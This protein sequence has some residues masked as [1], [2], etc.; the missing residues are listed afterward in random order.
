MNAVPRLTVG[1]PVYN[2]EKYLAESLDALLG[3][4]Y[5][6]YRMI[7]SDNASTDATEEICREYQAKDGRITYFRQ[8]VNIGATPNHN[9]CF[10]QSDTELFKWASYD[11]L[12]GRDLLKRC[13]EA[14]DDDPYLVLA[15]AYQAIIDGAGD[16]VLEVDY[17]LDTANPHAPDRFRSLLFDV[18]GDDFYGVMRSD[19]LRRTPLNGSYHHSDRTIMAELALYGRFAQVPELLFFRRD[20]PDR[21]ERAKPTIRSRSANMEPRRASRLRNPT[22]RL[23]AEYVNGFVGGIRRAPLSVADRREC[24]RHLMSWL[25]SRAVGRSTGRIEDNLPAA[26]PARIPESSAV[27]RGEAS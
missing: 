4:S 14:L 20:H 7:I 18:G 8:P 16:I 9:W 1:L 25:A 5:G 3:Q 24:Y 6:D 19:I 2:G 10:E 11:D 21:A 23:L 15:H 12:Y 27:V 26:P 13:V 17:P 22:V